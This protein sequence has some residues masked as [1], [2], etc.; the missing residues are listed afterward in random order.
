MNDKERFS[1]IW[2]LFSAFVLFFAAY[3]YENFGILFYTTII[4]LCIIILILCRL[5]IFGSALYERIVF[6]YICILAFCAGGI[7]SLTDISF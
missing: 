3:F 6:T 7:L 4:I 1:G 2:F 5:T